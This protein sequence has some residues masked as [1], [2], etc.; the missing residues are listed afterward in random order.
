M[1]TITHVITTYLLKPRLHVS[2]QQWVI[3]RPTT[4]QDIGAKIWYLF[5]FQK[6]K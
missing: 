1:N 4:D 5:F 3:L 6:K 2:T